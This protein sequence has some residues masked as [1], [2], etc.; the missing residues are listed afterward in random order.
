M[1]AGRRRLPHLVEFAG[2]P[3][4]QLLD[5]DG[6]STDGRHRP[7]RSQELPAGPDQVGRSGADLLRVAQQ[8]WGAGRQVVD[9]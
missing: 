5:V 9:E 1:A 4:A 2:S 6:A 3:S 7:G 8:Q